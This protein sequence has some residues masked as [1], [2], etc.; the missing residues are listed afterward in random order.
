MVFGATGFTGQFVVEE[1]ARVAQKEGG[2]G[3][4][5]LRWAVAGRSKDKLQAAVEEARKETG[6]PLAGV[7][8]L[9]A[10]VDDQA[11]VDA[12]TKQARVVINCVG[13]YVRWGEQV[14]KSCINNGADHV[15]ISGEPQFL[16]GM[17]LKYNQAAEER[18]VHVVGACGYDSIPAEMGINF[19]RK[20]FPG[21]LN[22]VEMYNRVHSGGAN[23]SVHTGTLESAMTAIA[24]TGAV[25]AQRRKLF[26][27]KMPK[28]K[29][30]QPTK[31]LIHHSPE[32]G[33][34]G[35]PFPS[36]V[37]VVYRSQRYRH[38]VQG[39]QPL[40][41]QQFLAFRSWLQA[42]GMLFGMAYFGVMSMIGWT[43]NLVLKYP[44]VFTAGAFSK[45]GPS[46]DSL[47]K[48]T[49]TTTMVGRGWSSSLA[50]PSDQ[51]TT[52]PDSVKMLK[53]QG[54]DPGYGGTSVMLVASAMTLLREKPR[55]VSKGGV[56]TP[57]IAFSE[58]GM[59]QRL[60]DRGMKFDVKN[61]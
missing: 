51:H 19:L 61:L 34:Y 38:D 56:L 12:M 23:S 59:L 9:E 48:T 55:C 14:V 46:R 4:G 43:R 49:F 57:A 47:K 30:P 32:T 15:D 6:L 53:V 13:P 33:F 1:V 20:Q 52:P 25:K 35:I 44:S 29:F 41:F 40:Q 37:P 10:N 7:G 22:S 3:E 8:I 18:G 2:V 28:P 60:L 36:D 42:V 27:T 17:Q 45:E 5:A 26:T 11:S 50:E 24:N 31:S 58:T 54:S 39:L 21:G 16:E